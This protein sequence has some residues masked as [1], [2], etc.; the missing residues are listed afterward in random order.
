MTGVHGTGIQ[1]K[2]GGPTEPKKQR[3]RIQAAKM[4]RNYGVEHKREGIGV[5]EDFLDAEDKIHEAY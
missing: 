3:S 4:T 1:V 5:K 2:Q